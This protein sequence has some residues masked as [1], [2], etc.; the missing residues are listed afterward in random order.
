MARYD[1]RCSACGEVFE[2]E[3]GMGERP[4]IHCPVCNAVAQ[5]EFSATGI[6]FNGSGF[7]NTDHRDVPQSS[8]ASDS[9]GGP[10]T[11][12]AK[13]LASASA[14]EHCPHKDK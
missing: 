14:C 6:A 12:D 10:T 5:K 8:A 3:H 7:Y 2:V 9:Q 13:Q 4:E 1:Y 11:G